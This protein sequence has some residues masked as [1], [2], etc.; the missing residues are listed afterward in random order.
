MGVEDTHKGS[1]RLGSKQMV[2]LFQGFTTCMKRTDSAGT[3]T[4]C[5]SAARAVP[6]VS[7]VEVVVVVCVVVSVETQAV[8]AVEAVSL[9]SVHQ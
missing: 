7:E 8:V 4:P 1:L 5:S 9:L 2:W 6:V 3:C